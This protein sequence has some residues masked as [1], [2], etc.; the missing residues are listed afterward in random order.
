MTMTKVLILYNEPT[1][2]PEHPDAQSEHEVLLTVAA[3]RRALEAGGFQV[4]QL[5]I[6]HD[7]G[8]LLSGLKRQRPDAVFNL[9]E[10][11]ADR[12]ETEAF[13]DGILEW[14]YVPFTGCAFQSACL[15]RNK[16]LT[17]L[18]LRSAGLPT[19]D[20]LVV[21]ELPV[22]KCSLEWPVIV[23]PGSQDA[24]VGIDQQSVVTDQGQLEERAKLM[25]ES[26]G[27]PVLIES[28]IPGRE[29]NVGVVDF[30]RLRALPAS[31]ILFLIKEPGYWPILTYDGKWRPGT[32]ECDQTP[33]RCPTELPAELARQLADLA[34]RAYRLVG[35]RDYARV[36]FRVDPEGR[37]FILEVNPNPDLDPEAGFARGLKA[38]GITYER[39]CVDLVRHV[40][41]RAAP[42][43]ESLRAAGN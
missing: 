39:F 5:G 11:T 4:G 3:V 10:G 43:R 15:G 8:K 14:L 20:F 25:L 24:S 18:L 2:P 31:E 37:P 22:P 6:S 1:L 17:K 42:A 27:A 35:C 29:I 32:R 23:K 36:D 16:P 26:Y 9:F 12:G 7:P 41:K 19:A 34:C 13:A 38:A 28:F 40:L 30:P 33:P 21:D